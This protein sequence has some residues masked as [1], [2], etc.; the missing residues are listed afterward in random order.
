MT[1][2]RPRPSRILAD[3]AQLLRERGWH[4]GEYMPPSTELTLD[5]YRAAAQQDLP[6]CL[7]GA[8]F[9]AAGCRPRIRTHDGGLRI[10]GWGDSAGGAGH[11][12]DAN[13][14]LDCA[15]LAVEEFYG[16]PE[17]GVRLLPPFNDSPIRTLDEILG[18]LSRA[19]E[20]AAGREAG[21][22]YEG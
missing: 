20:L 7:T 17:P 12:R 9:L 13:R 14:A 18:V 1:A 2:T 5:A 4:Q 15:E 10:S 3:A 22:G 16:S 19:E 21:D 11:V 8:I 6:A